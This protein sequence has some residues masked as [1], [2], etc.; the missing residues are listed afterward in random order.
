MY[1]VILKDDYSDQFE[2]VLHEPLANGNKLL[3]GKGTLR[4]VGCSSFTAQIPPTNDYFHAINSLKSIIE[5]YDVINDRLVFEGR[6]LDQDFEFKKDGTHY[7]KIVSED[8]KSY[9]RDTSQR[10]AKR[11]NKGVRDLLAY[12]L[13]VHNEQ[14]ETHKQFVLGTVTVDSDTDAPY[15]WIDYGTTFDI[16]QNMFLRNIGG[17]FVIRRNEQK[18]L[19]LDYLKEV[20]KDSDMRFEYGQNVVRATKETDN[21]EVITVIEPLG[22]NIDDNNDD[23]TKYGTKVTRPRLNISS[24]NGGSPFIRDEEL[25]GVFGEVVRQVN[26]SDITD[27]TVLLNRGLQFKEEQMASLNNW[28][29]TLINRGLIDPNFETIEVGNRYVTDLPMLASPERLQLTEV[30]FDIH[31]FSEVQVKV[32]DTNSTLSMYKLMN[33]EARQSMARLN[34][35]NYDLRINQTKLNQLILDL[36]SAITNKASQEVI[37]ELQRQIDELKEQIETGG[38]N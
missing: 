28:D 37:D 9:F 4:L 29:L 1:R 18:Q 32:G 23:V 38:T 21:L 11:E 14:A 13:N 5:I 35:E 7:H 24:V 31:S 36:D 17:Y 15:R 8:F 19:V 22:A 30:N 12:V 16:L 6:V 2:K 10:Y 26:F 33:R 27:P 3:S 34:S 25:I 20:G